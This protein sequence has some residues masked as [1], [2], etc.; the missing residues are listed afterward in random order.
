MLSLSCATMAVTMDD[1]GAVKF[2]PFIPQNVENRAARH[3]HDQYA[4]APTTVYHD[5]YF[6]QFY[7]STGNLT[8]MY[9]AHFSESRWTAVENSWDHI[10][11]KYSKNGSVWSSPFIV[12]TQSP[13]ENG[14]GCACDPAIVKSDDGYWYML[15][16]GN[17][18]YPYYTNLYLAR[19]KSLRGPFEKFSFDGSNIKWDRWEENPTRVLSNSY[20]KNDNTYG[21]GQ[22]SIVRMVNRK[23]NKEE[24]HVWFA[25]MND[26]EFQD[27]SSEFV[28]KK[29][30]KR[31]HVVV[32]RLMD[33]GLVH[34]NP[35]VAARVAE[36]YKRLGIE[37]KIPKVDVLKD[38]S[39]N[40]VNLNDRTKWKWVDFGD[41][42]WNK[43]NGKYEMWLPDEKNNHKHNYD[44]S[45][46]KYISEDGINWDI[47]A[48]YGKTGL[49][50][51]HNIGVSGD[52]SGWINGDKYLLSFSAPKYTDYYE[53][54]ELD[55]DGYFNDD[56]IV[57]ER[58][59]LWPMW[60]ILDGANWENIKVSLRGKNSFGVSKN[61]AGNLQF[62]VGDFDGDGIDELGAVQL[63]SSGKL[64][65]YLRSSKNP[66]KKSQIWD[67][68]WSSI[69]VNNKFADSYRIVAGDYDGDGKTDYGV[70]LFK[71]ENDVWNT[72]WRIRSSK[73]NSDGV[74][75]IPYDS[76]WPQVSPSHELL[77]GDFDGDG[78]VDRV[79][80]LPATNTWN[81]ISSIDNMPI[82]MRNITGTDETCIDGFAEH[83]TLPITIENGISANNLKPVVND[84]DGD[85]IADLALMDNSGNLYIRSSQTG[86]H[87]KFSYTPVGKK[88]KVVELWP[89]KLS[90]NKPLSGKYLTGDFDGDGIGD[91]IVLNESTG[92]SVYH[93]S[94]GGLREKSALTFPIVQ[95]LSSKEYFVGDFDGNGF[96]DVCI[97]DTKKYDFYLKFYQPN[98]VIASIADT[99]I[100][101]VN[102]SSSPSLFKTHPDES[103]E[104]KASPAKP[105]PDFNVNVE[106]QKLIVSN[107]TAGQRVSVFDML[108]KELNR[109]I[110]SGENLTFD[111]PTRGMYIVRA[112]SMQRMIMV[113]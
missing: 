45:I 87:L 11:Y 12:V 18:G 111:T 93:L 62:F 106:G 91:H 70:V 34:I 6:H 4:Y 80:F 29:Y 25:E 92:Y 8:D 79:V 72:Y 23:T 82:K 69:L 101:Y 65:W 64:K 86:C 68:E 56:G 61:I 83:P 35:R 95:D 52:S 84:F 9:L 71:K 100:K 1:I 22:P 60:H 7:C 20:I 102:L 66:K 24:F 17:R 113:K 49:G 74:P 26:D 47:D 112:G 98:D 32:D 109:K 48:S 108:G 13:G 33:L 97:V 21:I 94:R 57:D 38:L 42:R 43:Y 77:I 85:H 2:D 37:I 15:Y 104:P 10:R 63:L 107:T 105:A 73:L 19:S 27:E 51:I 103:S 89:Y 50:W 67:I 30:S 44:M 96:S 75:Y 90:N 110:S 53:N 40:A 16:A 5:G 31:Y 76:K 58:Y 36:L 39:Q 59:G 88:K 14:E 54:G 55:Q 46:I 28:G 99:V 78:K 41:V 81:M 3:A